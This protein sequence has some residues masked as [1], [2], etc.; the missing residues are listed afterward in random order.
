MSIHLRVSSVIK[1]ITQ[2]QSP[3]LTQHIDQEVHH[4]SQRCFISVALIF[5]TLELFKK[6]QFLFAGPKPET[7]ADFWRMV[8]E[9]RSATIVMLTNIR[10]RKEVK[11]INIVYSLPFEYRFGA[12]T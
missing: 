12:G 2:E 4:H 1:I 7:V 5:V 9:H 6:F 11:P 3:T 10:E 8:W